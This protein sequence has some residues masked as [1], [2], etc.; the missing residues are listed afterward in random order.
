MYIILYFLAVL[1]NIS[2]QEFLA[3]NL[4]YQGYPNILITVQDVGILEGIIEEV[5]D[6]K[7]TGFKKKLRRKKKRKKE[8][9]VA[10]IIVVSFFFRT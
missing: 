7:R 10:D 8:L 4:D 9:E 1:W 5:I 6:T 2:L 3:T